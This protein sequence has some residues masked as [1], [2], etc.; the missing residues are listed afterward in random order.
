MRRRPRRSGPPAPRRARR[1]H[2]RTGTA[3]AVARHLYGAD[4][5]NQQD[6]DARDGPVVRAEEGEDA[7]EDVEA[8]L[9][10]RDREDVEV[11]IDPVFQMEA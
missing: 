9:A 2:G 6:A 5:R 11:Q 10:A 1:L 3:Y 7:D 8:R 4:D